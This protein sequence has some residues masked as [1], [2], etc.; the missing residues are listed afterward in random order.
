[1]KNF[2]LV[3]VAIIGF[4]FSAFSQNVVIQTN[5]IDKSKTQDDCAYR[6]SGICTTEDLGGVEVAR[7]SCNSGSWSYLVFENYNSLTVSVIYELVTSGK[8]KQA[9]KNGKTYEKGLSFFCIDIFFICFSKNNCIFAPK[10]LQ[11]KVIFDMKSLH[12]TLKFDLKK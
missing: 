9:Q 6:I 3:F 8:K 5:E 12:N 10:L 2:F 7:G 4:G 11:I 1:M